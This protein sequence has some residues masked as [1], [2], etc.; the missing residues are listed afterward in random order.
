[1]H[2]SATTSELNDANLL[3]LRAQYIAQIQDASWKLAQCYCTPIKIEINVNQ[4]MERATL[5]ITE[6]HMHKT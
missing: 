3:Y 4:D 1:M 2:T 6:Y 5:N